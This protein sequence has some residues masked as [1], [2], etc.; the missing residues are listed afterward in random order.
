[1]PTP[2]TPYMEV[3]RSVR[4]GEDTKTRKSRRTL[5]LPVRYIDAMRT[6]RAQQAAERLAAGK[7]GRTAG[8][9]SPQGMEPR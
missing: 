8:S 5:A 1:M 9:Y 3:R 6:Q 2:V 7:P 4:E